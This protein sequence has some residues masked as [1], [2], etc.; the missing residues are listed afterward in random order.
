L[1]EIEAGQGEGVHVRRFAAHQARRNCFLSQRRKGA[2][3]F[4]RA[5]GA[6]IL[7]R[8][9]AHLIGEMEKRLRRKIAFFFAPLRLCERQS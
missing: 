1:V 3:Y 7:S 2:K 4:V 6:S 5:E 9:C 8:D